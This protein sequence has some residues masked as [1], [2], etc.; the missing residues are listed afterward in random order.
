MGHIQRGRNRNPFGN[1]ATVTM[2]TSFT[3]SVTSLMFNMC[4]DLSVHVQSKVRVIAVWI[5]RL[6]MIS[7]DLS[8]TAPK[9]H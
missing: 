3:V 5:Y 7:I 9:A 4:Q 8:E 6:V 1:V 2:Q